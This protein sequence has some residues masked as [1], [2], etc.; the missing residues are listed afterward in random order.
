MGET[1]LEALEEA[2]QRELREATAAYDADCAR[3]YQEEDAMRDL[4]PLVDAAKRVPCSPKML[5]DR[6]HAGELRAHGGPGKWWV[7]MADVLACLER[8]PKGA[9]ARSVAKPR[10]ARTIRK[11][12][13]GAVE[14][15][16][17]HLEERGK[18]ERS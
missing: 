6:V 14:I 13:G 11:Q 18:R 10:R 9:R 4:I 5:R 12:R 17:Q 1:R 3:R 16:R 2:Y 8:R 7:T 15:A